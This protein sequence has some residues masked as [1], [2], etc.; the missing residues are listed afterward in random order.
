LGNLEEGSSTWMKGVLGMEHLSL[1]RLHGGG[2]RWSSFTEDPG[3]YVKKVSRYRHL[4]PWGLLSIRG[5]PG[6]W[7]G[8]SYT[9]DF[10]R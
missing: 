10:D 7:G 5:E 8:G 6:M 1:K 2:L 9:W 4:S 3:I